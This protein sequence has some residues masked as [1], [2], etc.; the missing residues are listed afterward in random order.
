MSFPYTFPLVLGGEEVLDALGHVLDYQQRAL[1]RLLEQYREKPLM[2]ALIQLEPTRLQGLEDALWQVYTLRNLD[3]ASGVQ[4]DVLGR[5]LGLPRGGLDDD[6]YRTHLRA[7]ILL[8]RSSGTADQILAIIV[9][10]HTDATPVLTE[11]YPAGFTVRVGT[12]VLTA[13]EAALLAS[14]VR[15]G[16]AGG[17]RAVMEWNPQ[18]ESATFTWDTVG[19]GWDNGLWAGAIE[20]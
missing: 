16:R 5:I 17:V 15:K 2:E 18:A 6:S 7:Q 14:F 8:L 1:L 11:S 9:A 19:L 20:S 4:L 12:V 10:A 3:S 13:L